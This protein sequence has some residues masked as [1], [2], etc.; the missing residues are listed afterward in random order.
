MNGALSVTGT[1]VARLFSVSWGF[2]LVLVIAL[3]LYVIA[4]IIFPVNQKKVNIDI[5]QTVKA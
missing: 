3:V 5:E 1:M 4:G 2:N